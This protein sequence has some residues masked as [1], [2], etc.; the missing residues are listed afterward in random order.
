MAESFL[1]S[2]QQG[3]NTN[4]DVTCLGSQCVEFLQGEQGSPAWGCGSA[5]IRVVTVPDFWHSTALPL[6]NSSDGLAQE[7]GLGQ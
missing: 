2:R 4:Y 3:N 5:E 7:P 1:F 6:Q